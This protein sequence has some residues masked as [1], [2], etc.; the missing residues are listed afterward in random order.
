[1]PEP[2][3]AATIEFSSSRAK[4]AGLFGLSLIGLVVCGF[5]LVAKGAGVFAFVIGCIGG[6][7]CCAAAGVAMH[8]FVHASEAVV[9][10]SPKGLLDRRISPSPIPWSAIGDLSEWS[11]SGQ[12]ILVVA[13][14]PQVE[15]D[16]QLTRMARL[17]R[18]PNRRLGA[19][20]LC[21][22]LQGLDVTYDRLVELCV[23]YLRA[24]GAQDT[25][26]LAGDIFSP[27]P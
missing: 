13:V 15:A 14:D 26:P 11:S 1:M 2:D 6:V 23:A 17:S 19:D 8:R 16:L 21:V 10:L 27:A 20:G 4:L 22:A 24:W 7:I 18:A 12:R 5:L 25:G 9:A 3:T